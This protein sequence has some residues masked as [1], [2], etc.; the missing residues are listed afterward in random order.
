MTTTFQIL[1]REHKQRLGHKACSFEAEGDLDLSTFFWVFQH[2]V[3]R[4]DT[5]KLIWLNSFCPDGITSSFECNCMPST[6]LCT[7]GLKDRGV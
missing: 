1:L 6:A 2:P 5:E 7:Y 3:H 4:V